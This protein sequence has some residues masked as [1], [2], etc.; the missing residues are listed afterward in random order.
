[1][2][3]MVVERLFLPDL[4][5]VEESEKKLC[6][7]GVTHILCDPP[8]MTEGVYFNH[9]WLPL[10][11]VLLQLFESSNELQTMS[12]AEKK[13]QLQDEAEEELL[14]GLDD[15]PGRRRASSA[16]SSGDVRWNLD[17]TPA[18]SCLA[19]AKK[20][21]TDILGASI[22]DARCHLAKCLQTLTASH[23]SQVSAHPARH[24]RTHRLF[25][26]LLVSECHEERPV[27][28]A[29]LPHPEVLRASRRDTH[30][31]DFRCSSSL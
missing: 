22:P 8:P 15:T 1:M 25:F 30:M 17:Y 28:R 18:F 21:H 5:K 16:E 3:Q 20:P 13:K 7:V 14:V 27:R 23:P 4:T 10:L 6:A 12:A 29:S 9:L 19:F 24:Y 11:Q 31:I 2:F 26:S